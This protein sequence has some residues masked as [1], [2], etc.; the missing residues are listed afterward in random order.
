MARSIKC[1]HCGVLNPADSLYCDQC[2]LRLDS[3]RGPGD[4]AAIP[5]RP[6]V[7]AS[8]PPPAAPVVSLPAP[9]SP[10]PAPP[11][12]P[13]GAAPGPSDR[14]QP[15]AAAAPNGAAPPLP[16]AGRAPARRGGSPAL[17]IGAALLAVGVFL[18]VAVAAVLLAGNSPLP[19]TTPAPIAARATSPPAGSSGQGDTGSP[20]EADTPAPES[21]APA[22]GQ[23]T[24]AGDGADGSAA[25]ANA[26]RLL[27]AKQ[28]DQALPAYQVVL[29]QN[30]QN[31]AALLGRGQAL[32]GLGRYEDAVSALTEALA[33]RGVDD[34]PALLARAQANMGA[35][36]NTAAAADADHIL[37][38]DPTSETAFLVRAWA[39][40]YSGNRD[41]AAADYAAALAAYP[42]DPA[43]YRARAAFYLQQQGKKAAALDDLKQATTLAPQDA[44]LWVDLGNA[45]LTYEA[46]QP[47]QADQALAAY[48]QAITLDPRLA[49][50]YYQRARAYGEAKGDGAR[51][52][53]DINQAITVGP[54]TAAMYDLRA[55][56]ERRL[57]NSAA[58]LADLLHAVEVDPKNT[59]PYTPLIEA[60]VRRHDY[61]HA[62]EQM[63]RT[64]DLDPSIERYVTRS[65]LRLLLGQYAE[66]E[67]DAREAIRQGPDQA[68]GQI[69]LAVVFFEQGQYGPALEAANAA[70]DRATDTNRGAALAIRGR[71]YV[72]G[73]ALDK[74]AADLTDAAGAANNDGVVYIGQAELEIA[75]KNDAAA[76]DQIEKW[77]DSSDESDFGRGYLIRAQIE[78]RRGLPAQA[79]ADLDQAQ[80]RALFPTESQ[81]AETLRKQ[82]GR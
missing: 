76:L 65:A 63:T 5:A 30:P 77:I 4:D 66:A 40:A 45:Y 41:G 42:R 81:A 15:P 10:A 12:P 21:P 60:Y 11:Q 52:L 71:V 80:Q 16:L 17:L 13:A 47:S 62:V 79:R 2:S 24:A 69:A 37:T 75:R 44:G 38:L 56:I 7:S 20:A 58:E 74:A 43:I 26:D 19:G 35:R 31:P 39:R 54:A 50:A 22:A 61:D 34:L 82:L 29:D 14:P 67:A 23:P 33:V 48:D 73:N 59:D 1:P 28:F 51:A 6:A 57:G 9:P 27:A 70:V 72:R 78:A 55:E 53:A 32:L 64:I 18:G 3:P 8:A 36:E 49:V 46:N 68:D 25:T